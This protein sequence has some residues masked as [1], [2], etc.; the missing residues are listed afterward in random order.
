LSCDPACDENTIAKIVARQ[1]ASGATAF[2]RF[3]VLLF[4]MFASV[5]GFLGMNTESQLTP[6]DLMSGRDIAQGLWSKASRIFSA[7]RRNPRPC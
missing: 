1:K 2:D 4:L 7:K 3:M 5:C 6:Y